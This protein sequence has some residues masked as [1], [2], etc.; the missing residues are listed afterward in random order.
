MVIALFFRNDFK[1]EY[2]A[3]HAT[4]MHNKNLVVILSKHG[5]MTDQEEGMCFQQQ[6]PGNLF[7]LLI[8]LVVLQTA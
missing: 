1:L 8:L 3:A 7:T 4:S 6:W 5:F 2:C